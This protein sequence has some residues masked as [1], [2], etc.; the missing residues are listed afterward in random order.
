[1]RRMHKYCGVMIIMRCN[2]DF[3]NY[4]ECS[5]NLVPFKLFQ[6]YGSNCL[7]HCDKKGEK[8]DRDLEHM[9]HVCC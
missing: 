8:I 9:V 7:F 1:M 4:R 6:W 2:Y 5:E 3:G